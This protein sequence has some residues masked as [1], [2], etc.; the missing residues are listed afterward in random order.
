V[1]DNHRYRLDS[2]EDKAV[3]HRLLELY[4]CEFSEFTGEDLNEHGLYGYRYLDHYWTEPHRHAFFIRAEDRLAGFVLIGQPDGIVWQ[5]AEFFV[6]RKYRHKGIGRTAAI[7]V[8]GRFPG[9]WEVRHMQSNKEAAKFWP[10]VIADLEL[11]WH[12]RH[13]EIGWAVYRF[14][15]RK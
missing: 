13:D 12:D 11:D 7:H 9:P 8:F 10:A 1:Y 2:V 15:V 6:L 5:M 4:L 14:E 3:L